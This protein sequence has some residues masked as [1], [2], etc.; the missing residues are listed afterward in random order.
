MLFMCF[1]VHY[2]IYV[3]F[4]IFICTFICVLHVC[5]ELLLIYIMFLK[6]LACIILWNIHGIYLF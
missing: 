5:E 1:I 6:I 4:S 2:V 3:V